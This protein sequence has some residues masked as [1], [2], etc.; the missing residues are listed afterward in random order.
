MQKAKVNNL[1]ELIVWGLRTG[2]I[3]DEPKTDLKDKIGR[4]AGTYEA[5]PTWLRLLEAIVLGYND[6]EIDRQA[7]INRESIEYYKKMIAEKFNLGTPV[8]N[9]SVSVSNF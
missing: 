4:L 1:Y 8:L 2:V 7:G 9:S 5:H 6:A 3:K